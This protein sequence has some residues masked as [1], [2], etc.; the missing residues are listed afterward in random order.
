MDKQLFKTLMLLPPSILTIIVII[1]D[2]L[3]IYTPINILGFFICWIIFISL[4]LLLIEQIYNSY[5][6]KKIQELQLKK[7]YDSDFGEIKACMFESSFRWIVNKKILR[8]SMNIYIRGNKKGIYK[9]DKKKLLNIFNNEAIIKNKVEEALNYELKNNKINFTSIY[10]HFNMKK[11]KLFIIYDIFGED[12][13]IS[14]PL[15]SNETHCYN[16]IFRNHDV[17]G[18]EY[19]K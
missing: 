15:R 11:A 13:Y 19:Q 2:G 16:V 10:K 3:N 5:T 14:C 4:I 6:Y 8:V 17:Y 7:I 18:V 12:F 9:K 1:N